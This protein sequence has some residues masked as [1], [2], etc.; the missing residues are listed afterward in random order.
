MHGPRRP[1]PAKLS[2]SAPLGPTMLVLAVL[3]GSSGACDGASGGAAADGLYLGEV[4]SFEVAEGR[5]VEFRFTGL[6]CRIP[7]PEIPAISLCLLRPEGLPLDELDLAGG[8]FEGL[9]GDVQ[10]E[11]SFDAIGASGTWS[12]VAVC[13][14]GTP[15]TATGEW[16]ADYTPEIGVPGPDTGGGDE[17]GDG[18]GAVQDRAVGGGA[19]GGTAGAASGADGDA[20]GATGA[21]DGGTTSDAATLFGEIRAA[22]GLSMPTEDSAISAAAQAHADYYAA[23]VQSYNS[24][25]LNAHAENPEWAEGFTGESVGDRLAYQGVSSAGWSEVMAFSGSPAGAMAGWMATLYHRVP[26]VHPNTVAWGFGIAS[27]GANCE[28]LDSLFGG[29]PDTGPSLWPVPGAA[30][31]SISWNGAESPKPPL[32]AT[33]S[34]PSGP[35]VTATFASGTSLSLTHATLTGPAGAEV[36]AQVQG[37]HNDQYLG[38]TWALYAYDP[39]EPGAVYTVTFDGVVAGQPSTLSWSFTTE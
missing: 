5:A 29:S 23:H 30:G 7:H 27:E 34:Y 16:S 24:T 8:G 32:P 9:V 15:C 22:V 11:G 13:P 36:P 33:E 14:D 17:T 10:V 19:G 1:A 6:E 25:G 4:V 28:V 3:V 37:P 31:V 26:L 21:I 20:S 2:L 39:L 35:V 38:E 12:Y 18:T